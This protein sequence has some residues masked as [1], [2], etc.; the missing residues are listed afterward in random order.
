MGNRMFADMKRA[1]FKV[2]LSKSQL[3]QEMYDILLNIPVGTKELKDVIVFNLGINGQM[4][5]TRDINSIWNEIKKK[6]AKEYPDKFILDQRGVLLWNDGST[7][8]IDKNIS[9]VILK[10]LINIAESENCDVNQMIT[11]LIDSYQKQ[12]KSK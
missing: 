6:A 10:K 7:N 3:K 9:K 2:G 12:L 4:A 1:G 5:S 11:K 8:V